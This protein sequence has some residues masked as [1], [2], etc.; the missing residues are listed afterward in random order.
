MH[1]MSIV[2]ALIEQCKKIAKKNKAKKILRVDVKI[3]VLS[4]IEPHFFQT[5]FDTFKEGTICDGA[6]L[7]MNIQKILIT[8]N[9]CNTQNTLDQNHFI[10][11]KCNSEN[12]RV[13]DGEDMMLMQ[14]EME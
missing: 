11:P 13:I 9:D 4:G 3:G 10:C 2:Q 12:I 14:L 5:T 1:E 6:K 8:C 7:N